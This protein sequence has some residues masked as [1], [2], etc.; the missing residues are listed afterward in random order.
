MEPR[1]NIYD[2]EHCGPCR[3]A[4][5]SSVRPV[6]RALAPAQGLTP[7]P[8]S[9]ECVLD[10]SCQEGKCGEAMEEDAASKEDAAEE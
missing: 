9:A 10:V 3:A 1:L 7:L 2:Y 6:V 8:Y 5:R 4:S